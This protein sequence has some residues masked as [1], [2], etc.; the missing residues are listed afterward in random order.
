MFENQTGWGNHAEFESQ[1]I[2]WRLIDGHGY[3][4][5]IY[6]SYDNYL[7]PNFMNNLTLWGMNGNACIENVIIVGRK[8]K[9]ARQ[10]GE[11]LTFGERM[12]SCVFH[13]ERQISINPRRTYR[14]RSR[15]PGR[16]WELILSGDDNAFVN[17]L[18]EAFCLSRSE[19]ETQTADNLQTQK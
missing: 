5:H 11:I 19:E 16:L 7:I 13:L 3:F 10:F 12:R 1:T 17:L 14:N 15:V 9:F 8:R 2:L 18:L 6:R 4:C